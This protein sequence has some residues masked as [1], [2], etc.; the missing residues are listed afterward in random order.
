[1]II[2]GKN[3]PETLASVDSLKRNLFG[4]DPMTV[5]SELWREYS[6]FFLSLIGIQSVVAFKGAQTFVA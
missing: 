2:F 6:F 5:K 3:P 1:M 4:V